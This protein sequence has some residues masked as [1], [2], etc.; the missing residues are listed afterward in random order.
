MLCRLFAATLVWLSLLSPVQATTGIVLVIANEDYLTLRDA[1]GA[2]SV[3]RAV[4][5]FE[6]MG[7]DVDLATDLSADAMRAALSALSES[8]NSEA[9]ERVVIVF[10]GRTISAAHGAW[11]MGTEATTPTFASIEAQ[12]V[13][14]ETVLALAGAR[15]GGALVAIADYGF[16]PPAV[17][18]F[19]PGLPATVD[20]P[21]G[22]TLV[23]GAGPGIADF[24]GAVAEPGAN[25]GALVAARADL[26]LDGFN[27]PYLTFLP[28][29]HQPSVDADR[30]AW[31]A[32]QDL[33]TI[34]GFQA[35]LDAWPTGNYA[36]Q[37]RE[38]LTRL[39]NTPERIEA[40]LALTRDERRAIQRDLTI[41]GYE[42]RGIDGIFGAGTRAAIAAWQGANRFAATGFL[43]RDQIF[44]LAQQG[45][46]RAAQLEA[47]ARQ[48]QIE[49]ERRDRAYWRDTGSGTDEVG[50]RA[51]LARYPSGIF[52]QI[53]RQRL[54][55]IEAQR[56]AEEEARLR[57]ADEA[58][59]A[60]AQRADT[61]RAYRRY[62]EAHPEGLHASEARRRIREIR[63]ARE[64]E[65]EDE[66]ARRA[67]EAMNMPVFTRHL[68][69]QQLA[70]IGMEPGPI[71]GEFDRETRAAIRRF[72]AQIGVAQTGYLNP[73]IVARLMAARVLDGLYHGTD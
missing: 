29:D 14:L 16:P 70:R 55:Q 9:H 12:G 57:A 30:Q 65:V 40:S 45:A 58:D 21:Q 15:Q 37:A 48:R 68:I 5:R 23:R 54:E 31:N 56:R 24:L 10:A 34:E 62:L 1:S 25:I 6:D 64:P 11:L 71:D 47:E 22:V 28:A 51:Y 3:L 52:A 59:W 73:Q 27:P 53:A 7:F 33:G 50:M 41:L 43:N 2:S 8:L 38:A 4:R 63:E 69:E 35:Y 66:E 67:E 44:E 46:R 20:V 36:A 61:A 39:L 26:R 72:Q 49:E 17:S 18:G 60:E 19:A 32:A 13:R 42:P